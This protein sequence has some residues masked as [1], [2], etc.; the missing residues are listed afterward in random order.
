MK[1]SFQRWL[2]LAI[3][4]LV[5]CR[6]EAQ[7]EGVTVVH[8]AGGQSQPDAAIEPAPDAAASEAVAQAFPS[9]APELSAAASIRWPQIQRSA[10]GNGVSVAF[11]EHR[12]LPVLH[13]RVILRGAGALFDPPS[14]PG[15]ASITAELLREGITAMDS[16]AIAAAFDGAG[17]RFETDVSDDAVTLSLETLP[18]RAEQTL[19]LVAKLVAEPTFPQDELDRLRRRELDRLAQE[20]ADPAWLSQRP[21]FRAVYGAQHPYARFDTTPEALRAIRRDEVTRFHREHFLKGGSISIVAVGALEPSAFSQ[22]AERAFGA[23]PQGAVARPAMPAIPTRAAREVFIVDRP[24]S[25]QAFV[26]V[27]RVG[28]KRSDALWPTLAVANQVLGA[29]PS[30]RL[31]V[32]LRERRSLT[33]GVY[34]RVTQKV[35]E[36]VVHAAGST[37]IERAGDFTRALLEHLDR[38]AA[39]DVP[40]EELA[41]AQRVVQNRFPV[42]FATASDLA[43]RV[44]ESLLYGLDQSY[45]EGYPARAAAVTS[46]NVREVGARFFASSTAVIVVVG[47]ARTLRPMLQGLGPITV[48]RPGQ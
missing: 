16:R 45:Y 10:L 34:S 46:G 28:P 44:S 40:A 27:G 42:S 35:D 12:A 4:A 1:V 2:A 30:S 39:E 31:F 8:N 33:Y 21:F 36:G 11:V 29:A 32:D 23:I 48:L 19:A 37:R 15:L 41:R 43:A 6:N 9:Q 5:A 26:R 7:R 17:A 14:R 3:T 47:P 18:E 20:M 25:A 13:V 24:A 38:M 22:L